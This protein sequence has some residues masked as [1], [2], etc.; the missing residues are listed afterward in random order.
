MFI[1]GVL[2]CPVFP[3]APKFR[4]ETR[5]VNGRGIVLGSTPLY[6]PMTFPYASGSLSYD[7]KKAGKLTLQL[8]R[9]Y[10]VEQIVPGNNFG[11]KIV[12]ISW[13]RSF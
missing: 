7:A 5:R 6:G 10:Y 8:Q 1:I 13:T 11:A 12:L 2:A 9:T 3:Q 4:D